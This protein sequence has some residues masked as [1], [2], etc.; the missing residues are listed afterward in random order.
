[1]DIGAAPQGIRLYLSAWPLFC[2]AMMF[3]LWIAS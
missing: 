2:A 3:G 1:M